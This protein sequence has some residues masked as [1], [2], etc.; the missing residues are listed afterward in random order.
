MQKLSPVKLVA[1]VI[2]ILMAIAFLVIATRMREGVAGMFAAAQANTAK[3]SAASAPPAEPG[4][5]ASGSR[6]IPI[7]VVPAPATAQPR[8]P[9]ASGPQR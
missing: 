8:A 3:R 9:Q 6:V 5:R 7:G 2:A 4:A 1:G